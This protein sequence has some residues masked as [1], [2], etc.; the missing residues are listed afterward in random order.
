[1]VSQLLSRS[2]IVNTGSSAFNVNG[3]NATGLLFK[4]TITGN[5]VGVAVGGGA[6]PTA[7]ATTRSSAT[8]PTSPAT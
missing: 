8:Q 5:A 2:T 4:D 6:P 1:M 3:A 7:S